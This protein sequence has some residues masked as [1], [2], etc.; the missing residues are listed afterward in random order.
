MRIHWSWVHLNTLIGERLTAFQSVW[1]RWNSIVAHLSSFLWQNRSKHYIS[2]VYK[3]RGKIW[4]WEGKRSIHKRNSFPRR[5]ES[6]ARLYWSYFAQEKWT[7]RLRQDHLYIRFE[8]RVSPIMGPQPLKFD[9]DLGF[10]L[11]RTRRNRDPSVL[12]E[13]VGALIEQPAPDRTQVEEDWKMVQNSAHVR[14]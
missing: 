1:D 6:L 3:L 8:S 7:N 5:L 10:L 12:A 14:C 13:R 11:I 9:W 4:W 2:N